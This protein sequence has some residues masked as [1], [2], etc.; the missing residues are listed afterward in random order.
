MDLQEERLARAISAFSRR[1]IL[2]LLS[3][4][5]LTVKEIASKTK[6]S[7]SLA[8]R[9]L[10]LLY[11]LGF[12]TVRKKFPNKFYSVKVKEL[13]DLLVQYDK[14]IGV[15]KWIEEEEEKLSR[16]ISAD[17]RR[18]ILRLVVKEKLTVKEIAAKTEISVSLASRH[19]KLLYDLG[20][21]NV[22][23]KFPNKF[24]SLKIQEMRLLLDRYDKVITKI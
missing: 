17:S 8:S 22:S 9:H 5:E 1:Q 20:F 24:Y 10:K 12:L 2:R 4:K 19:L 6:M 15:N 7:V 21:L 3:N 14:T 23:R 16:A 11:D 13:N 18:K